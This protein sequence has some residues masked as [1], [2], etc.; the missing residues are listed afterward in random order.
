ML[1]GVREPV[2]RSVDK[3]ARRYAQGP[4][5][6]GLPLEAVITVRAVLFGLM[7]YLCI[8]ASGW[9]RVLFGVLALGALL[10]GLYFVAVLRR[11]AEGDL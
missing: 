3:L 6:L 8:D 4:V 7:V 1:E 11:V 10:Q 5:G 2:K 9:G